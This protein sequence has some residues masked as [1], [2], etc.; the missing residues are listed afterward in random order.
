MWRKEKI[1]YRGKTSFARY[2]VVDMSYSGRWSRVLF[3][4]D[5]VAAFS[6]TPLDG[7]KRLLFDYIES[8]F[9]LCIARDPA[10][11][12]IIGGGALT[13]PSALHQKLP[14]TSIDVVEIDPGLEVIAEAFFN[15]I[16]NEKVTIIHDD[17]SNYLEPPSKQYDIILLDVF[18]SL[19]VPLQFST[20]HTIENISKSLNKNGLMA[21]NIIASY[22]GSQNSTLKRFTRV[23]SKYFSSVLVY[24]ADNTLS[25]SIPQNFIVVAEESLISSYEHGF[26]YPPLQSLND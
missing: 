14:S 11:I 20:P 5:R 13:L 15:Y 21:M 2:E 17:G 7:N 16:P 22:H 3:A 10:N 12:L 25:L 1:V 8:F 19:E 23:L 6:G 26:S 4:N 24:P 18:S 9:R